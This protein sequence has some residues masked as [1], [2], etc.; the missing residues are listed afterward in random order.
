MALYVKNRFFGLLAGLGGSWD[1]DMVRLLF[2]L[3]VADP[4]IF[5]EN[6]YDGCSTFYKGKM[7]QNASK[8]TLLASKTGFWLI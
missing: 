1:F 8:C 2:Q 3:F 4:P 6:P 7:P 5:V